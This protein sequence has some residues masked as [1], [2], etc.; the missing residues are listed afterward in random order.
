MVRLS[1]VWAV[2]MKTDLCSSFLRL[3]TVYYFVQGVITGVQVKVI[4]QNI[5]AVHVQDRTCTCTGIE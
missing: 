5:H 1:K 3:I 2:L 4:K